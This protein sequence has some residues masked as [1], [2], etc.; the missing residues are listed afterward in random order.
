MAI[1]A[2]AKKSLP[3]GLI[4]SARKMPIAAKRQKDACDLPDADHKSVKAVYKEEP[5]EMFV[6][7]RS[8]KRD[9]VTL[10][11]Q[12]KPAATPVPELSTAL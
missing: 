8:I 6:R 2:P 3:T 5:T 4:P 7:V 1:Q 9:L 10:T 12:E 11:P